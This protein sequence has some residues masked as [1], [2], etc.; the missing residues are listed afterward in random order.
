MPNLMKLQNKRMFLLCKTKLFL[1]IFHNRLKSQE[2]AMM[3]WLW[4]KILHAIRFRCLISRATISSSVSNSCNQ[5]TA[6]VLV[7]NWNLKLLFLHQ[8]CTAWETMT[9]KT[10]Q[11]NHSSK[12]VVELLIN[13]VQEVKE[14]DRSSRIVSV[15]FQKL[16]KP[17]PVIIVMERTRFILKAR[18]S[19]NKRKVASTE[20]IGM[21]SSEK[22]S[23]HTK[24][25]VIKSTKI[26]NRWLAFSSN[27]R[28]KSLWRIT[29]WC[30]RLCL[31][32][33]TREESTTSKQKKKEISGL[34][35]SN[36]QLDM[37]IFMIS[38]S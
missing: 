1:S 8:R 38:L 15:D 34:K 2:L 35:K 32:S 7:D 37:L 17:K 16:M 14:E 4:M 26:C 5:W 20:N 12:V 3:T 30:I 6:W 22:S 27:L 13:S 19:R 31:F 24:T 23:T 36:K 9:S 21:Y 11:T 28:W 10:K 25:K 33:Q 29:Q 18:S